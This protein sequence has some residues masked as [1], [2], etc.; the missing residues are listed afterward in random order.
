MH[1]RKVL[2]E[3]EKIVRAQY[4][5]SNCRV[6]YSMSMNQLDQS[7]PTKLPAGTTQPNYQHKPTYKCTEE[8]NSPV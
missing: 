3:T 7:D 5:I 4:A 2:T 1:S 6:L 8:K